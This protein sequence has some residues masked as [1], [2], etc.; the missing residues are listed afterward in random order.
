M[1]STTV[2]N[3]EMLIYLDIAQSNSESRQHRVNSNL[4]ITIRYLLEIQGFESKVYSTQLGSAKTQD[5][6]FRDL[7]L[8]CRC[9][10]VKPK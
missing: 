7:Q 6:L 8:N 10:Q 5:D 3:W 2:G 9:G 4:I 1:F